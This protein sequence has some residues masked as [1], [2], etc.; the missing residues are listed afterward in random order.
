MLIQCPQC[1]ARYRIDTSRAKNTSTRIR[2]PKCNHVFPVVIDISSSKVSPPPIQTPLVANS[3]SVLVVDDSKFFRELIVDVLKPM[4]LCCLLAADA[5]E[6]FDL[7]HKKR[8]RLI[9]VDLNLPG[10]SG[11]ELIRMVR[12]EPALGNIKILALS[13][14]FRKETA[15]I[16]AEQAGADEFINK[17]FKPEQ[18]Q[19]R[20]KRLLQV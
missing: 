12:A 7:L 5:D 14:V 11:Y 9:L 1:Q 10:K 18:L 3:D 8:I 2:C 17:S 15:S 6:A 19:L 13:G 20:V 4:N 16:E